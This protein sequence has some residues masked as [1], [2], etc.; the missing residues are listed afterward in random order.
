MKNSTPEISGALEKVHIFTRGAQKQRSSWILKRSK[1]LLFA[2][3]H[4]LLFPLSDG[5]RKI[6]KAFPSRIKKRLPS[7]ETK[8]LPERDEQIAEIGCCF[9]NFQRNFSDGW[10]R[11]SGSEG[12]GA[13]TESIAP[14]KQN[15]EQ[16]K[17]WMG[18]RK[19]I[20]HK[21][22][23]PRQPS[24]ARSEIKKRSKAS[25]PRPVINNED[26]WWHVGIKFPLCLLDWNYWANRM[27]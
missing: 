21:K 23:Q 1:A 2:F 14:P 12:K 16:K 18:S 9:V 26:S 11:R 17:E 27:Y 15:R 24:D 10:I 19:F 13:N 8:A 6:V 20:M 25:E 7:K 5:A 3:R 4:A 22:C